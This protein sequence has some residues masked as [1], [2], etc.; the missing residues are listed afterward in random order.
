M[1]VV[2]GDVGG[3]L[4]FVW[5]CGGFCVDFFGFGLVGAQ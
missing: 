3:V 4:G 1:V 5:V 2:V